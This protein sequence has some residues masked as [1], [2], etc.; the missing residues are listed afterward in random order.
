MLLFDEYC[1]RHGIRRQEY[2]QAFAAYLH[3]VSGGELDGAAERMSAASTSVSSR[4][5]LQV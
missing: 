5:D 2:G 3:E 4:G 1:Q